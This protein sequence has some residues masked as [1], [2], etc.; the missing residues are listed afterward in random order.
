MNAILKAPVD[1][2]WNGGIGTYVKATSESHADAQDRLTDAIRVNGEEL[3]CL[4]VGEGGNLGCTQKGRVEFA[5]KGGRINTDFIDNSA[6]VDCSDHEVNIKILLRSVLD[7]GDL[8]MKQRDELL[9]S[10]TDEVGDLVL[11]DNVLQNLALSMSE[12]RGLDALDAQMRLMRKLEAQGRLDR[13]IEYLPSDTELTERRK[14]GRGLTRPES[15]VLLAY[16][17][18]TLYEDLLKTELPDRAYLAEDVAKYFPRPL[19]RGYAA[20]IEH[21]R[22]KRE[23]VSTW[24]ANSVVNRGLD[25]FVSELED[26]TGGTLEDVLLAYIA[27]RDAFKLLPLWSAIEAVPASVPGEVQTRLLVGARGVLAR[28]TRWFMT[29]GGRPFKIRDAVVRFK[30]GIATVMEHLDQVM[31]ASHAGAMDATARDHVA[32]GVAPELARSVAGLPHLLSACDIVCV[33]PLAERDGTGDRL[34]RTARIYFAL[35]SALDLPWLRTRVQATPRRGPWDRLALTGLEDDL[36]GVLRGLTAA[37]MAAGADGADPA[38]AAASVEGWLGGNLQGITRYRALLAEL[39]QA[40]T[41]DLA[42]V[43]VALRTL[44]ELLPRGATT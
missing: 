7:A 35:D 12:Q 11:R 3:R 18:M 21:H 29:Q 13:Q 36:S 10:M 24:I 33:T 8:T 6:G 4:V 25:V 44:G 23:I 20:R 42:M 2:F 19:R 28:G 31:A 17:K 5:L 22:L 16:S 41:P 15:A 39:H 26:E 27:A 30:P 9:A 43:T 34:L 32:A 1:L 38:V 14:T 37:A 40:P